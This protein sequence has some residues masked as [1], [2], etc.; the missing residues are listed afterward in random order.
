[1]RPEYASAAPPRTPLVVGEGLVVRFRGRT[2][3]E[4]DRIEI[5]SGRTYGLL[6]AS[7]AG[8]STLLRVLGLLERTAAGRVVFDGVEATR[9]D[10][11]VRRS[12]AAVFQKPYLLRGTVGDNVAYGLRLRGVGGAERAGRVAES[13]TRVG[14]AG[15]EDHSALTLSGGEAQRVALAR[16]L[17]LRP[18]LLLLDEPLSYLDP[19]LKRD[20]TAEFAEI[21]SSEHVTAVYV[22]HDQDEA[23][24]VSDRIGVMRAGRIVAEGDPDEVLGLPADAW[25]AAFIG[26]EPAMRGRVTANADG[27]A[28]IDVGGSTLY[29]SSGLPV[30]TG[31]LLAVRPEDVTLYEAGAESLHGSARNRL[32][33]VVT[34]LSPL[35]GSVRVVVDHR[36]TRIAAAVSRTAAKELGLVPGTKVVAVFKATAVRVRASERASA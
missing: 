13:L 20:L 9:R 16:A 32:D 22:T 30:G 27:L 29:A 24:V 10:L 19:L 28:S 15:W 14:L 18:R 6:G 5:E 33:A 25:V 12:I 26:M 4:V 3:L 31:V 7:G 2:V 1:M 11:T 23:A 17:V 34:E 36:G 35:G 8:K 21:L